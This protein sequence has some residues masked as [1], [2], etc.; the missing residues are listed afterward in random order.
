MAAFIAVAA[1]LLGLGGFGG[2]GFIFYTC[3]WEFFEFVPCVL[4]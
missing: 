2:K 1:L 4:I 3:G